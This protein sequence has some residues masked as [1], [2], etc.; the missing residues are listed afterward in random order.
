MK[1]YFVLFF[2]YILKLGTSFFI[3]F[4]QLLV[5]IG[6]KDEVRVGGVFVDG[7]I[8]CLVKA[9]L[10]DKQ[11]VSTYNGPIL[12]SQDVLNITSRPHNEEQYLRLVDWP[13]SGGGTYPE[14]LATTGLYSLVFTHPIRA[15][16]KKMIRR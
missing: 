8:F 14:L 3:S 16:F 6:Q 15:S 2:S 9:M 4:G 11:V 10:E 13:L 1:T 12:F 7:K 5:K